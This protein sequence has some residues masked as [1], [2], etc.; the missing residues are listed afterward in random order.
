MTVII[1]FQTSLVAFEYRTLSRPH[2]GLVL[3]Y[4]LKIS[5]YSRQPLTRL[6]HQY[7]Q[8]GYMTRRQQP[9]QGVARRYTEEDIRLQTAMDTRHDTPQWT[10]SRNSVSGPISS[11]ARLGISVLR[12]SPSAICATGENP[13]DICVSGSRSS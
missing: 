9:V 10:R 11:L 2:N 12:L 8:T 4:R 3:R 13:P 7:R 1:G 5:G 6:L